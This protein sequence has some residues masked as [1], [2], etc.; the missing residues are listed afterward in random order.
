[1]WLDANGEIFTQC[2]LLFISVTGNFLTLLLDIWTYPSS[3]LISIPL[4]FP[5]TGMR[6]GVLDS[7]LQSNII[8]WISQRICFSESLSE[9]RT[10]NPHVLFSLVAID[11]QQSTSGLFLAF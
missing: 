4:I 1:M 6:W 10:L 5:G 3:L 7:G 11:V 2:E 9:E 8:G